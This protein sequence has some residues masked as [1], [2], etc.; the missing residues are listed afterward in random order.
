MSL[1]AFGA[2]APAHAAPACKTHGVAVHGSRRT[3]AS[4]TTCIQRVM[5][6]RCPGWMKLSVAGR[7]GTSR[8]PS[9][10][11]VEGWVLKNNTTG[12]PTCS[13]R[14][15]ERPRRGDEYRETGDVYSIPVG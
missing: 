9:R 10:A 3:V 2:A 15:S 4:V 8:R 11:G 13:R 5:G 6:A 12:F 1:D 7:H 14:C